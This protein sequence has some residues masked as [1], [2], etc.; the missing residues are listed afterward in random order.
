MIFFMPS[1]TIN[2]FK[3]EI[4][5]QLISIKVFYL[6]SITYAFGHLAQQYGNTSKW[7]VKCWFKLA[8]CLKCR[9]HWSQTNFFSGA[10]SWWI[11]ACILNVVLVVNFLW[12]SSHSYFCLSSNGKCFFL[13]LWS[14]PWVLNLQNPI[15]LLIVSNW[16]WISYV[17]WHS[18]HSNGLKS[19]CV[20]ICLAKYLS[21]L[22]NRIQTSHL[23][24]ELCCLL[25]AV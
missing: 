2:I 4:K 18:W 20:T 21:S 3:T 10:E 8:F 1:Q 16:I 7:V 13:W 25:C 6:H 17:F 11:S 22:K 5:Q 14:N 19:E 12:H 23:I 9:P 24:P 15:L